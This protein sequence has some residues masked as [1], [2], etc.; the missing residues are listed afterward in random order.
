MNKQRPRRNADQWQKIIAQQ[1]ASGESV[2][3]Y[4]RKQNLC[5]KSFPGAG[6]LGKELAPSLKIL[7][8]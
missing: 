5:D 2:S 4:C 7:L 8:R 6:G 1:K 3:S